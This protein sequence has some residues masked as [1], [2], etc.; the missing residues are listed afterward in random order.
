MAAVVVDT[1]AIVWYLSADP[2]LSSKAAAALDG[3]TAAG[4]V[5]H[6]PSVCLVELSYLIEKGRVPATARKRLVDALDD[7]ATPC[8]LVPLDRGVADAVEL[9][10]RSEVP[11]LPDR[12]VSATAVALGVPLVSRDG[13]IRASQVETIW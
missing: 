13:R 10:T 1:H 4:E 5:I 9:V 6:V 3:A 12:I 2:R 8:R 11:D 7:P